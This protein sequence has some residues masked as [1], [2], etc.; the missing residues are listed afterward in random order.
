MPPKYIAF[1]VF[2]FICGTIMGLIIEDGFLGPQQQSILNKLLI[3]QQVQSEEAWGFIQI[4][5]FIPGYFGALWSAFIWDFSFI[6]GD[7]AI[8]KWLVWA[9][10][11]AMMIWGIVLTFISIFQK[12]LS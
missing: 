1:F 5:S 12:V 6:D 4:V 3:W 9:P 11:M 7:W 8:I 10:L 2:V